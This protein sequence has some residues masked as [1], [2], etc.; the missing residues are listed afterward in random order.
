[1]LISRRSSS[2]A[3]IE[4]ALPSS[5]WSRHTKPGAVSAIALSGSSAATKPAISGSS[6][7]SLKR[8]MFSWA[9]WYGPIRWRLTR[10]IYF[11]PD[12][13]GAL[14]G[15]PAARQVLGQVKA[16]AADP[17]EIAVA[18]LRREAH[19]LVDDLRADGVVACLHLETDR[20]VAAVLHAVGDQLAHEQPHVGQ[21]L[22][23]EV[24]L[25]VVQRA[26]REVRRLRRTWQLDTQHGRHTTISVPT[27]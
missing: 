10:E 23:I 20:P 22:G 9:R 21:H 26:P 3:W 2:N 13:R 24:A 7:G 25:E 15:A 19:A 11:E 5:V 14:V 4:V 6:S 8:A 27:E 17:V 16:P 12:V 1:M 18:R